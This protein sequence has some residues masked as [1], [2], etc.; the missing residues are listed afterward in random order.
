VSLR[1]ARVVLWI[2]F[3]VLAPVPFW[4]VEQGAVP[5]VQLALLLAAVIG[6]IAVEGTLGAA[7]I[8]AAILAAELVLWA[9]FLWLLAGL[10]ARALRARPAAIA[11]VVV[12]GL[13]VAS[14]VE[15]YRTPFRTRSLRADLLHVFE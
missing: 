15:I 6:V 13:V 3:C 7:P 8:A 12:T 14:S 1:A 9:F 2:A 11:A 10:L 5:V 4:L